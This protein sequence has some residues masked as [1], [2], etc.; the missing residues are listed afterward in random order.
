MAC[1]EVDEADAG[2]ATG[3]EIARSSAKKETLSAMRRG[4]VAIGR[5]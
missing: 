2:G 3:A 5:F 4:S 1:V